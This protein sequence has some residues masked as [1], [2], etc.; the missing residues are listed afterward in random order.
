MHASTPEEPCALWGT[1]SIFLRQEVPT[2]CGAALQL[3]LYAYY[4]VTAG[5]LRA[6]SPPLALMTAQETGLAGAFRSAHQVL[7]PAFQLLTVHVDSLKRPQVLVA[8][9]IA[10]C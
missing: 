9:V 2:M 1:L 10:Q 6:L 5:A 3:A 7:R 4:L 8:L